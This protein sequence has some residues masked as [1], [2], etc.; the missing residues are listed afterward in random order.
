MLRAYQMHVVRWSVPGAPDE[1]RHDPDE[2]AGLTVVLI[3][4]EECQ[5]VLQRRMERITGVNLI[6]DALGAL[7]DGAAAFCFL[8]RPAIAVCDLVDLLGRGQ[9]FEDALLK[10]DEAFLAAQVDRLAATRRP[11]EL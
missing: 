9:V 6:G 7:R 1:T 11:F 4:L 8:S 5:Q 2:S 3:V 10:D